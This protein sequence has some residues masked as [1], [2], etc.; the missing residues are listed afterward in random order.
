MALPDEHDSVKIG[1]ADFSVEEGIYS[2]QPAGRLDH[3]IQ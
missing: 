1:E 2:I 3:F